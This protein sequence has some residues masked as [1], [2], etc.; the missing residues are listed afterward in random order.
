MKAVERTLGNRAYGWAQRL[1]VEDNWSLTARSRF[2]KSG[3]N[4][5]GK[6]SAPSVYT[7]GRKTPW[8][9]GFGKMFP[10]RNPLAENEA[11]VSLRRAI[12]QPV[13]GRLTP[14]NSDMLTDFTYF[15]RFIDQD[16]VSIISFQRRE[17]TSIKYLE[18]KQSQ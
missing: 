15:D 3:D 13:P 18:T 11:M 2:D 12:A 6:D 1:L 5:V 14:N 4:A 7:G 17:G 9:H 10:A 16:V 8:S